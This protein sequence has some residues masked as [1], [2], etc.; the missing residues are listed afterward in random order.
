VRGHLSLK[1]STGNSRQAFKRDVALLLFLD[2][3]VDG[4]AAAHE[5][6]EPEGEGRPARAFLFWLAIVTGE[7]AR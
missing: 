7:Q 4:I 2:G 3:G 1:S 6:V 5:L